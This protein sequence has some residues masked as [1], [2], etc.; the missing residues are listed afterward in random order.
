M[1]L[2]D[3]IFS[4]LLKRVLMLLLF[5]TFFHSAI[6][7][8]VGEVDIERV[9]V[10]D[11]SLSL[12]LTTSGGGVGFQYGWIQTYKNRHF[13]DVAF[14]YTNHEKAIK[15]NNYSYEGARSY[16]YGKLYD[17]FFLRTGYGFQKTTHH[18]P[19]WGGVDIG[20]FLT[21]GF[22]L[23]IGVPTYLE[24]AY[25]SSSGHDII[26]IIERYDPSVHSLSNIIGGV[27]F[28][29]RF[30]KFAFRPGIYG[31]AGLNFDFGSESDRIRSIEIGLFVDMLFPT[32]Q[33]MAYNQAKPFFFGGYIAY[34]FGKRKL[35]YE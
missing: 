31:K 30:H 4:S 9:Y 34:N 14:L 28:Y 33:Q 10:S 16:S 8:D 27:P 7:Q 13:L 25:L 2:F 18:K 21:G 11:Y 26:P 32:I 3:S 5:S 1:S 20:Y 23:G 15:G 6:S 19:Y 29:E 35:L 24:I 22:S 12:F 17:V